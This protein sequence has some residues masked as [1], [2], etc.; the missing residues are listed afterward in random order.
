[1]K[2]RPM[3]KKWERKNK[4]HIKDTELHNTYNRRAPKDNWL[5]YFRVIRYY[6]GKKYNIT[7]PDLEM[8]LFL[9]SEGLFTRSDFSEFEQIM[10]W[11]RK[12]FERLREKNMI[13]MWRKA[14]G[15][16]PALY[17]ISQKGRQM[18]THFYKKLAGEEL[19]SESK[20]INPIFASDGNYMD[21]VY[22]RAI[23]RFNQEQ[24]Q[25]PAPE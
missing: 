14:K 21:K 18:V 17:E 16:E 3:R 24:R 7:L 20:H 10:S 22:R 23:K 13:R 11:D 19:I 9:Y 15:S 4:P 6:I 1:M 25:R 12:R 8:M 5:K 2:K